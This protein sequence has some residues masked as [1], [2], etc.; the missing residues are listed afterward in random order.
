MPGFLAESSSRNAVPQD[1]P[2]PS[3][4]ELLIPSSCNSC[5]YWLFRSKVAFPSGKKRLL[6]ETLLI[7][8]NAPN[9]V[10]HWCKLPFHLQNLSLQTAGCS[11]NG[12]PI[13]GKCF[14]QM[15]KT[16]D[17]SFL[18]AS[19]D[20][21]IIL[22]AEKIRREGMIRFHLNNLHHHHNHH[23]VWQDGA[24]ELQII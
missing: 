23:L 14:R 6:P 16:G 22:I 11:V 2:L 4:P 8:E 24:G 12:K 1:Q 7:V 9:T 17:F 18:F 5:S 15:L 21:S 20:F 3:A 10:H 13:V 19:P